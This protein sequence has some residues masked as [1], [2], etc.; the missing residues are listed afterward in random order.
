MS[1]SRQHLAQH[2]AWLPHTLPQITQQEPRSYH[3]RSQQPLPELRPDAL[4]A[5][6]QQACPSQRQVLGGLWS[7]WGP[8]GWHACHSEWCL[9]H[10]QCY[11]SV[12][13]KGD[14]CGPGALA[15]FL[16]FQ[17]W[18]PP[19]SCPMLWGAV[20]PRADSSTLWQWPKLDFVLCMMGTKEGSLWGL[21]VAAA[22]ETHAPLCW[23]R[24][25]P[26]GTALTPAARGSISF[27]KGQRSCSCWSDA[28]G[29]LWRVLDVLL[30]PAQFLWL[31]ASRCE[32]RCSPEVL[33]LPSGSVTRLVTLGSNLPKG[34]GGAGASCVPRAP[35]KPRHIEGP[36]RL[37]A[38]GGPTWSHL[39]LP[40]HD[41]WP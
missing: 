30:P 15:C 22:W 31:A 9:A 12:P 38:L 20:E 19:L 40:P 21:S 34:M 26:R 17:W 5:R 36:G 16:L 32:G 28:V 41:S 6:T 23:C 24:L 7:L 13:W 2:K 8:V 25:A 18:C 10:V 33:R 37:R 27:W 4:V 29:H 39:C 35:E 11:A 14:F 1:T 3:T